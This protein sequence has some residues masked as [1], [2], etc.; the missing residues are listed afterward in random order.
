MAITLA[1][2]PYDYDALEPHYDAATVRIHHDK[3][4]QA[5]VDNLNN[6]LK[7]HPDLAWR[8]LEDILTHLDEVPSAIRT[9]V[10][11]NAGGV[12]NHDFF[13]NSMGPGKGGSPKGK[14]AQGI[15]AAF[16]SF[17]AFKAKFKESALAQF[18]SGW[19]YLIL[20]DD[21]DLT[22]ENYANQDCPVRKG[23]TALLTIDVW[24]HAYYLK[25]QNRR[26]DWVD[27]WWNVVDWDKVAE[28]MG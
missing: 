17:D 25:W 18:G 20:A 8:S 2:L 27:T 3:H 7:D 5:Y 28:R 9:K 6:A 24:E 26:A 23:R 15:D 11:N 12:W 13:W 22:I 21:G 4:H 16:G 19:A 10:T 1:P 14:V